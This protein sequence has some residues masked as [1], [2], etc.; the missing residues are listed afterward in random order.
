MK[1]G[2]HSSNESALDSVKK[3][4]EALSIFYRT[5]AQEG[6]EPSLVAYKTIDDI[7][8]AIRYRGTKSMN[9]LTGK[10]LCAGLMAASIL[11]PLTSDAARG[12]KAKPFV[13]WAGGKGQLLEQL[14]ELLPHELSTDRKLTYVEPFVGGGAMLFYVL[15][16]YP[17]IKRVIINDFN[18]DLICTYKV[19]KD[20]PEE[21]ISFLSKLQAE[22]RACCDEESRK[23]YYLRKRDEY[24]KHPNNDIEI[25]A[26]FIFLNRTCFNGL[27]RVN[28]KG[29]FNVPFGKATNPMICDEETIRRDSALLQK[30]TI[31][32][33][34]F[35]GVYSH[36]KGKAFVYFDPPYRPLPNTPSFT[37]YSKD[38]FNDDEQKRLASF[39]CKLNKDG[40]KWLLSNSDP[41]NT[42]E[43]DMF[44]NE[45]YDGFHIHKVEANRMINSKG[46]SRGK[47]TELAICN[48]EVKN[49]KL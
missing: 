3:V 21:L 7:A 35:E 5:L 36:I 23:M 39:C 48:Y 22:Y 13:K 17:N 42:D 2:R 15:D 49:E 28:S 40:H 16:K 9:R 29:L 47:I 26:L 31:I 43:K 10:V 33:G 6:V 8:K 45:L 18:E 1:Q 14:E 30:V 24:N 37:A 38:G 27:Y 32:S 25:A 44:F 34:D 46:N 4:R 41:S 19:V 11:S 20:K 12:D